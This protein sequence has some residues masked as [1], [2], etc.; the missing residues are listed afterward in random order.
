[1][2]RVFHRPCLLTINGRF[3]GTNIRLIPGIPPQHYDGLTIR[4]IRNFLGL[5]LRDLG[6]HLCLYNRG[7]YKI[8]VSFGKFFFAIFSQLEEVTE[9]LL[10]LMEC[11]YNG[12]IDSATC[13]ITQFVS[14]LR[15]IYDVPRHFKFNYQTFLMNKCSNTKQNKFKTCIQGLTFTHQPNWLEHE[16][17]VSSL[18]LT[19]SDDLVQRK[20]GAVKIYNNL[21]TV[22]FSYSITDLPI[23]S[24][25]IPQFI[26][27]HLI[28][29]EVLGNKSN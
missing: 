6:I 11:F 18:F 20:M 16:K 26:R 10:D 3:I 13:K 17:G 15:C 21:K 2:R 19:I 8:T 12:H 22:I 9:C 5:K 29:S 28:P 4:P 24:S 1:M 23:L 27:S 14:V 25:S 7:S